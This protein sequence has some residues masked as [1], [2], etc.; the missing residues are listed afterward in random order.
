MLRKHDVRKAWVLL[1]VAV[2]MAIDSPNNVEKQG[3]IDLG[4]IKKRKSG[5]A[6]KLKKLAAYLS[7]NSLSVEFPLPI[8]Q[9]RKRNFGTS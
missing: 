7:Q 5:L 6:G 4:E 9:R 8:G 2:L 3:I 1:G